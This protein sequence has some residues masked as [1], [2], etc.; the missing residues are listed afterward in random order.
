[1]GSAAAASPLAGDLEVGVPGVG[2]SKYYYARV[3]AAT[4]DVFSIGS[5]RLV[6]DYHYADQNPPPSGGSSGTPF[7]NEDN[8]GN[9]LMSSATA[10]QGSG[11]DTHF[12]YKASISDTTDVDFYRL[13]PNSQ[14]TYQTMT[15]V[16]SALEVRALLPAVSVYD[17]DGQLLNT[18][19]V[20]ND[21]GTYTVQLPN[22][23]VG[24]NYYLKVF[25]PNPF[26]G[27]GTGNYALT[28]DFNS[29]APIGFGSPVDGGLNSTTSL[30]FRT[31]TVTRT[32]LMQF[33][34]SADAGASTVASAI[35][36]TIF[37]SSGH[38]VYTMTAQA[39]QAMST[40]TVYLPAGVYYVAFNAA[41]RTGEALP[42]LAYVLRKRE[43]ILP[44]DAYLLDPGDGS[45]PP[46]TISG[47]STTCPIALLDP[48]ADP[49]ANF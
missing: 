49:Y 22:A 16:V 27:R 14:T 19:L 29:V 42:A 8:H 38:A 9:D 11:L 25:A 48:I 39:G 43:L 20:T 7:F 10:L 37:D 26:G 36:M 23:Q 44:I 1:V 31:L 32:Q 3:E 35:R 15:V 34:L 33:T 47:E 6:L 5:Y 41:T 17:A 12:G 18:Q 30:Q 46:T 45:S 2:T 28:V 4:G 13:V 21:G 24:V 40:G